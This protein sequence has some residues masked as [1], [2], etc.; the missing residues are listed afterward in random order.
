MAGEVEVGAEVHQHL[1]G[2]PLA[3]VVGQRLLDQPVVGV[4][5]GEGGQRPG[6]RGCALD[7]QG[8]ER[9]RPVTGQR[10]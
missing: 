4:T 2:E 6:R 10:P 9:P 5:H 1:G 8:V 3:V 7:P